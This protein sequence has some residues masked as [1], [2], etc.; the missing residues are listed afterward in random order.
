MSFCLTDSLGYVNGIYYMIWL[1]SFGVL[2]ARE[3]QFLGHAC[4]MQGAKEKKKIRKKRACH[5]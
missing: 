1:P 4:G 3:V 2:L 5:G